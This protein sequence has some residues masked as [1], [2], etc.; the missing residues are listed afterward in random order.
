M[1]LLLIRHGLPEAV[2]T[3]DGAPADPPLSERGHQQAALMASWLK[4]QHI[5][6]IYSSP[7]RRASETAKPLAELKQLEPSIRDGVAEYDQQADQYIP[8]EELKE[9]DYKAWRK[10]M[11]GETVG[12]DFDIF[13]QEVVRTLNEIVEEN[14]GK[15]VFH[16][17]ELQKKYAIELSCK[18]FT[19]RG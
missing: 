18:L 17:F 15:K 16:C 1:E 4:D 7:M 8:V 3:D 6:Q 14:R 11:S 10:L 19:W 5:D 2:T 12:V 13:H 9:L